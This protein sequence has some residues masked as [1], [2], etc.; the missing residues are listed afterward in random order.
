[1]LKK[2]IFLGTALMMAAGS[3]SVSAENNAG[4]S[5]DKPA[6]DAGDAVKIGG[7]LAG[8]TVYGTFPDEH[9]TLDYDGKQFATMKIFHSMPVDSRVT[10][11][12]RGLDSETNVAFTEINLT[13][14]LRDERYYASP[15]DSVLVMTYND[16]VPLLCTIVLKSDYASE[17]KS[18]DDRITMKGTLPDGNDFTTIVKV[19]PWAGRIITNP[20]ASLMLYGVKGATLVISTVKSAEPDLAALRV[21]RAS[22]KLKDGLEK[23]CQMK[24]E[25][26]MPDDYV[27]YASVPAAT[28]ASAG[29][30]DIVATDAEGHTD[31]VLRTTDD[32]IEF[33]P[34]S[35]TRPADGDV[36]DVTAHGA[37]RISIRWD[38]GKVSGGTI[39]Y[40]PKDYMAD[41]TDVTLLLN[42]EPHKVHITA[43]QTIPLENF[44]DLVRP[45]IQ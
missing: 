13:N 21:F 8:A 15:V 25:P 7:G 30:V 45:F 9:I 1:M 31:L 27:S 26:T 2:I 17:I 35:A 11:Y 42:G 43:G 38:K 39:S 6:G 16:E 4:I 23:Y 10:A 36:V 20:D 19:I 34:F 5:F 14:G 28:G 37:F 33:L 3:L 24:G 18:F 12:K 32:A 29:T 40:Y 41:E 22:F 44:V